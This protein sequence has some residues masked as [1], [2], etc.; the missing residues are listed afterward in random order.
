MHPTPIH[1]TVAP[2]HSPPFTPPSPP[3][4]APFTPCTQGLLSSYVLNRYLRISV[5]QP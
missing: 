5:A 2:V 1:T 4:T 3:F